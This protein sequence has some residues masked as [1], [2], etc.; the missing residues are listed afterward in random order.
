MRWRP[1]QYGIAT[2]SRYAINYSE[3][4]L[5]SHP[6]DTEQRVLLETH[7]DVDGTTLRVFNTHLSLSDQARQTQVQEIL[8]ITNRYDERTIIVGDFNSRPES[9]PIEAL[10]DDYRDVLH[11]HGEAEFTFR[12]PPI[13]NYSDEN[14]AR[15]VDDPRRL[16]YVF[17]TPDLETKFPETYYSPASDHAAIAV[18]VRFIDE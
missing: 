17:C 12:M 14:L 1:R 15:H 5:L 11:E 9:Q 4:H 16:D 13:G 3:H 18:D 2:A 10:R 7:I 6:E 8:E